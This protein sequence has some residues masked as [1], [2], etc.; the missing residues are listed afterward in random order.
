MPLYDLRS[1]VELLDK[2]NE[3]K[4]IHG[5]A[6]EYEIGAISEVSVQNDGPALL[7]DQIPGYDPGYRVA[8]NVCSTKR[9]GQLVLGVDGD[10]PEEQAMQIF[11]D[12]WANFK[13]VL[14]QYVDDGPL[15]ENVQMG[16][17]VGLLQFPVPIWHEKDG[18]PYIGTG[19]TVINQDPDTG[20]INVGTYRVMLHDKNTT[21]I[22]AEPDSDGRKIMEKWWAQGKACPVAVSFGPDPLLFLAGCS[23]SGVPKSTSE[24]DYTGFLAQEPVP[25]VKG[26]ITGLP[27]PARSEIAIEGEVPPPS[28][29]TRMEGPFGEWTGYYEFAP[30]PE[31]VIRVKA[32][33]YRNNP[34]LYGAP[35]TKHVTHFAFPLRMRQI[36]GFVSRFERM[37]IPVRRVADFRPLGAMVVTIEQ[38][39]PDDVTRLMDVLEQ[40][41]TPSRLIIVVDHDVD[42][43]NPW[44]VLWAV[45]TRFDPELARV[46]VVDS[47]WL[48]NP[49]REIKDRI[50]RRP[51]DYKRMIINGCRPFER[52]GDFPPVNWLS[53]EGRTKV[54][55]K[56]DMEEWLPVKSRSNPGG[57]R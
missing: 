57:R 18:G 19:H 32:L 7:F 25:V 12:R 35:P 31:P 53:A 49:L 24:F 38:Q 33:Y 44:D 39:N 17:D 43:D 27:I 37:E 46:S 34:I 5:A 42:P 51:L 4:T 13:P 48:L 28:E 26:R 3:L 29:E 45:G 9:R 36:T 21:G 16:D 10:M 2:D 15:Y 50:S 54:W 11:R 14:P 22:F 1:F 47:D 55:G 56:W 40:T 30:T 41:Q 6:R 23:L 52:L 20:F 8:V